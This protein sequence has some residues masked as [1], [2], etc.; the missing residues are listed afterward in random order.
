MRRWSAL[1]GTRP[2]GTT[3]EVQEEES[4]IPWPDR[5]LEGVDRDSRTQ[6]EGLDVKAE[7]KYSLGGSHVCYK[8]QYGSD[9]LLGMNTKV[10]CVKGTQGG[11]QQTIQALADSGASASIISWDL[12]KTINMTIYEK[13]EATLKDG[14]HNHMDVSGKGEIMVQEDD[15]LPLKI[16]V[17]VSKSLGK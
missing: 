13:G 1:R 3:Q 10:S 15:G 12:A 5:D 9:E 11:K 2:G 8:T 7:T 6:A 16:Q 4:L 14:S 17:L